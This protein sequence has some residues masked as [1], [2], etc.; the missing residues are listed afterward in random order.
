MKKTVT[1]HTTVDMAPSI[2]VLATSILVSFYTWYGAR[3]RTLNG[4]I[5]SRPTTF[6][7]LAG[8]LWLGA[9]TLETGSTELLT[10]IF[11]NK[12]A[13]VGVAMIPTTLL[14]FTIKYTGH[15]KW[16]TQRRLLALGIVPIVTCLLVW[17]NDFHGLIWSHVMLDARDPSLPL[18][19]THGE[20]F[21]VNLAYSCMMLV[22]CGALFFQMTGRTHRIYRR[23]IY[24]LL[25]AITIP[26]L[27]G[28]IEFYSNPLPYY[29]LA[30]L[31]FNVSALTLPWILSRWQIAGIMP[32]AHETVVHG[33][34]DGVIVL[35]EEGSIVYVNPAA[36]RLISQSTADHIGRSGEHVLSYWSSVLSYW[37]KYFKDMERSAKEIVLGNRSYGVLVSPVADWRGNY[38][39]KVVTF[40]DITELKKAEKKLRLYS[41]HLEELVEE[42]TRRLREA[43]RLATIGET[44]AMVGHDLRNPLQGISGAAYILRSR[45]GLTTDR[46]TREMLEIIEDE[47][48]YSNKI[49]TDLLDYSVEMRL[50]LTEKSPDLLVVDA[51]SPVDVPKNIEIVNLVEKEP[52]IMVDGE[53]IKRVFINIIKNAIDAMP[54]GGKLT[55][56]S[57]KSNGSVE[58]AF[59]D[60]GVGMTRELMEKLWKP[61]HTTKAK[62]VGL[63][64]A[65]CKRI[66]EAHGGSIEAKSTLGKGSTFTITIPTEPK[67]EKAR[68]PPA[69]PV[70]LEIHE[71]APRN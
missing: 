71:V 40:H 12:I 47:I 60:T 19:A 34:S 44:A 59:T 35:D 63:G 53:K 62:G 65:V 66:V 7:M 17:T 58:I 18:V 41:E 33:M 38:S 55:I 24:I 20:W 5:V 14:I 13:Y 23:Q 8:V 49:I 64:L 31:T 52:E 46:K 61:L 28:A 22:I 50:Q 70:L 21:L 45:L 10:K 3:R 29:D 43:E 32:V 30:A 6:L 26:W 1:F 27:T 54:E 39:C 68:I 37:S 15:E 48:K 2:A 51:L 67:S 11:W 16:L 25:I 9:K 69:R 36:Q 56:S 42:R 57:K 4:I